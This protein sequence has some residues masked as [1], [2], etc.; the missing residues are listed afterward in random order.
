MRPYFSLFDSA[1]GLVLHGHGRW[2]YRLMETLNGEAIP[3]ILADGWILPLNESSGELSRSFLKTW[4][5][6]RWF[7]RRFA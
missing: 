5:G 6:S 3:V 4:F 1:Y 7:P 2:S